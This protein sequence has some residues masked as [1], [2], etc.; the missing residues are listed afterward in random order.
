MKFKFLFA[1]YDL[2]IGFFW[3]SA[4][5]RL[6][7]F[8]VPCLGCWVQLPPRVVKC[9]DCSNPIHG[10]PFFYTASQPMCYPCWKTNQAVDAD[11]S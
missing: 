10:E 9:C 2:W 3:D 4:K 7:F 1:W 5:R 6:Y 11:C 8:P